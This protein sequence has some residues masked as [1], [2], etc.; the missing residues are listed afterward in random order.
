[1]GTCADW[2]M[3]AMTFAYV[4][5]TVKIL[6]ANKE[7]ALAAKEQLE[8]MR[9]QFIEQNRP[10][11]E[12]EFCFERNKPYTI[13]F[14]NNGRVTAENVR[15]N[16]AQE[17]IDS[18][19][20]PEYKSFLEKQKDKKCIIGVGQHYDLFIGS[21]KIRD[22]PN[23][24]PIFGYVQY[25]N[26]GNTYQSDIYIDVA[27]YMTFFSTTTDYEKLINAINKN[28]TELKN[29]KQSILMLQTSLEKDEESD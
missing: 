29:I 7:A 19:T 17:F 14:I 5:A 27:N 28:T 1:M 26:E 11:I 15:I 22:N 16:L 13:R 9:K 25:E 2:M 3:V 12:V 6:K 10:K 4:V 20:E 24:K 18:L 21:D 8:E 23:I